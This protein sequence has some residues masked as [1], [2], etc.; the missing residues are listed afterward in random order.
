MEDNLELR[1]VGITYNQIENGVY[2]LILE[3]PADGRRLAIVIGYP[4]AQSIECHLQKV[5]TP[6]PLAHD[7]L[8]SLLNSLE[9][10]LVR[11]DIHRLPSGPYAG[12]LTVEN[13]LGERKVIDARSSDAIALAIRV[14]API[15]TS[16][17]LLDQKGYAPQNDKIKE[18]PKAAKPKG[19]GNW[20]KYSIDQLKDLLT[21]YVEKENYE[22]AAEIR[23][24]IEKRNNNTGL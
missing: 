14:N 4:E 13:I 9:A 12:K 11:V 22:T 6:R 17:K 1:L 21:K 8:A 24:E 15:Y 23:N 20:A 19:Q 2:A 18:A 7:L 10:R 3:A 16:R 5:Q